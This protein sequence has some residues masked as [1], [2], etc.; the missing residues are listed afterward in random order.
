MIPYVL[1]PGEE[2]WVRS[3]VHEMLS[4]MTEDERRCDILERLSWARTT[5]NERLFFCTFNKALRLGI[6]MFQLYTELQ[7]Q[8]V[9]DERN[10]KP[11]TWI[12]KVQE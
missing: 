11:T 2:S 3:E 4:K 12:R 10:N 5:S 6:D 9:I 8:D 1:H 7:C